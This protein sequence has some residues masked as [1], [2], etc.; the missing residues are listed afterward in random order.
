MSDPLE[1]ARIRI[2]TDLV[3]FCLFLLGCLLSEVINILSILL[4][5][6]SCVILLP[7]FA[8]V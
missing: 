1:E 5:V 8:C 2:T 6:P 3:L 7:V 4:H